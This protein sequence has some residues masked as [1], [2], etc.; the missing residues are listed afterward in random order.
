MIFLTLDQAK[1]DPS[2]LWIDTDK[3]II[4]EAQKVTEVFSAI[5]LA[6]DKTER[7][8]RFLISG[9]SNLLLMKGISETLAGR[10]VYFEMLP[11]TYSE[12][13]DK[14]DAPGKFL[15]LWK[16]DYKVKEQKLKTIDP[17]PFM[18]TQLLQF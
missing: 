17:V 7:K 6:V 18:L 13:G 8:K 11:M 2:S 10:A 14:I 3:V 5:K 12:I 16:P 15:D 4:D 9:S 1:T